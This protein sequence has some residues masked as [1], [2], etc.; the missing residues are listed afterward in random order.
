MAQGKD[1]GTGGYTLIP[2]SIGGLPAKELSMIEKV[3]LCKII[4]LS[5]GRPC[6]MSNAAFASCFVVT[7]RRI[8]EHVA[9]LREK[10]WG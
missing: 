5:K 1:G 4:S 9:K 2:D 3:L 8:T 7:S 6:E 10:G